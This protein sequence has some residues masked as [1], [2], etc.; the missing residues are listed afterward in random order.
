MSLPPHQAAP[1]RPMEIYND[2]QGSDDEVRAPAKSAHPTYM[3]RTCEAETVRADGDWCACR[4]GGSQSAWRRIHRAGRAPCRR[5]VAPTRSATGRHSTTSPTITYSSPTSPIASA[6]AQLYEQPRLRCAMCY[7]PPHRLSCTIA[8]DMAA[9]DIRRGSSRR[10]ATVRQPEK[11]RT[12][13]RRANDGR[14]RGKLPTP[15]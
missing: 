11:Q 8:C 12:K 3:R 2:F 5:P 10:L 6:R 4:C 13:S 15:W 7:V 1:P 9:S 14:L